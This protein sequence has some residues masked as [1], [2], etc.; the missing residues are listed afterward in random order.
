MELSFIYMHPSITIQFLSHSY[1]FFLVLLVEYFC[2]KI[3]LFLSE[4]VVLFLSEY[5]FSRKR[6]AIHICS[7]AEMFKA[8][9]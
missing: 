6:N 1:V 7:S 4:Y 9:K 8:A 3:V 2:V 5:V